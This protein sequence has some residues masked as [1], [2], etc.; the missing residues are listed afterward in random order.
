M[1]SLVA[2]YLGFLFMWHAVLAVLH[3]CFLL[4]NCEMNQQRGGHVAPSA[5]IIS[6]TA[7]WIVTKE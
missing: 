5:C 2:R 4:R 6:S 7:K 3:V 1:L